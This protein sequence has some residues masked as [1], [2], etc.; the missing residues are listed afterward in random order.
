VLPR[1][2]GLAALQVAAGLLVVWIVVFIW[3][4]VGMWSV[5]RDRYPDASA[6]WRHYALARVVQALLPAL[7]LGAVTGILVGTALRGRTQVPVGKS[8]GEAVPLDSG[9]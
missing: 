6:W 8:P 5:Q 7:V 3:T 4:W 9:Q 2:R 1:G